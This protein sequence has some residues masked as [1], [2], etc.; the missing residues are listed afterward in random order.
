MPIPLESLSY[1]ALN[2][3]TANRSSKSLCGIGI[4]VIENG[5]EIK[6][7]FVFVKPKTN[8][9]SNEQ[10]GYFTKEK[11]LNAPSL[12]DLWPLLLPYIDGKNIVVYN[13]EKNINILAES[14]SVY[15][16]ELPD[17]NCVDI[18]DMFYVNNANG[19]SYAG[20]A[21]TCGYSNDFQTGNVME[22][23]NLY[24]A[25][26][27]YGAEKSNR[28]LQKNFGVKSVRNLP[29]KEKKVSDA[30]YSSVMVSSAPAPPKEPSFWESI[31]AQNKEYEMRLAQMTPEE[32]EAEERANRNVC[33]II[34]AVL[35]I[36]IAW[37]YFK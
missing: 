35:I 33:L 2:L 32:R 3:H 28:I 14:L 8:S 21:S 4:L 6:K 24:R 11:L 36:V 10:Y 13:M 7:E 5:K 26:I 23:L 16:I 20:L 15:G 1:T 25:C 30:E 9:F 31:E 17:F 19:F 27:E 37:F 12:K 18:R 34:L 29:P 22:N